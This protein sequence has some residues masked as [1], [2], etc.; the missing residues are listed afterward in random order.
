LGLS[1]WSSI[2]LSEA[3]DMY[4]LEVMVG[5]DR[6]GGLNDIGSST[7]VPGMLVFKTI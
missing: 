4:I 3:A 2:R 1:L 7:N 6:G 5:S